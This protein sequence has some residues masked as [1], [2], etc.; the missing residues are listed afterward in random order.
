[1]SETF[2][3]WVRRYVAEVDVG[4]DAAGLLQAM[5][6][7][8]EDCITDDIFD[9]CIKVAEDVVLLS[10]EGGRHVAYAVAMT[11]TDVLHAIHE[12]ATKGECEQC[13][14]TLVCPDCTDDW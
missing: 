13:G 3:E 4:C 10:G 7:G 12:K 11:A 14:T 9:K 6:E 2:S 1:M 8:Y 5:A